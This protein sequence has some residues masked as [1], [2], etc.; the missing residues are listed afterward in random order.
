MRDLGITLENDDGLWYNCPIGY[1]DKLRHA[2]P[3]GEVVSIVRYIEFDPLHIFRGK[4]KLESEGGLVITDCPLAHAE[5]M[6]KIL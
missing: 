2:S 3:I 6:E 5:K 4:C 1:G